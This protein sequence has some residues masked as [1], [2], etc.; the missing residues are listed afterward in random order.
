MRTSLERLAFALALPLLVLGARPAGRPEAGPAGARVLAVRLT[1]VVSPVMDDILDEAIAR[2]RSGAYRA[3]LVEL[4]TPGGLE[5]SM[6]DMVGSELASPVPILVWVTPG[7]AHAASA[8]VFI[9]LAADV[10]AMSPGTNIGAAT[11]ISL[12]GPMDSTLARKAA[13]DAAAFARTVATQ[14]GRNVKWAERAVREAVAASDR[15]A[16]DEGIV[17]FLASSRMELLEKADGRWMHRAADSTLIRVAG[18][19]V[20]DM[21]PSL[22]HRLLAPLVDPNVAYLLLMLGFYGILFELQ[23]PGAILPGVAG[24]IFLVLAFFALSALPVNAAGLALIVLGVG[25]LLAEIKVHSHGVLAVGGA[26]A[27]GIGG[28][29]LFDDQAVRVAWPLVL[30]VTAATL[31]FFLLV[32]GFAIRGRR[33]PRATGKTALL[34]RRAEVIDRLS[35][36][37]RVRLDGEVWNAEAAGAI[38]VGAQ[39]VVTGVEGLTL[40]VR[41]AAA[42]A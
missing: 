36:R 37:G 4:N 12:Q 21:Q 1:G 11:P 3:L 18:A 14:R 28:L 5:S 27:L 2:A 16:V 29:I 8:G 39:V 23:N 20:D 17:D 22:R 10:A 9:T 15:E 40:R 7:G 30:A 31:A 26:L 35:P 42:E 33:G 19:R 32:I 6:R 13:N 24:A 25:F 41:P 38:D 34:G